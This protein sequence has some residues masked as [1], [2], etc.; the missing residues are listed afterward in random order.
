MP[1]KLSDGTIV[2]SSF[3]LEK[4]LGLRQQ[5]EPPPE[6]LDR[7]GIVDVTYYSFD[8]SLH[9]GQ[10]V[11][12]K[13]LLGD[14]K[15]AFD[16][17][18]QI[19]F[20]VFSVIP[21]MDR[22]FMDDDEKTKTVNNSCGFSY[23]MVAGTDRLSNHSFGRAIDIN[24]QINPYIKGEHSYGLDYD[25]TRPGTLTEDSVIVQYFKSRGWE[26][27]GDWTDRKDYMHFEKPLPRQGEQQTNV[28]EVKID[29]SISKDL[30]YK[31]QLQGIS[32]EA[33]FVLGGGN[34]E[35]TDSKGRKSHKTSPYKGKFFP[36]KTG[37]AKA[38]P[39]AAVELSHY[40]PNAK[41]VTMSHRPNNLFQLAE[42]ETQPID[43]PSFASVLSDDIKRAGVDKDRIIEDPDSTSTLTEII[44]V[45]KISAKNDWQNVAV[46]TNDYQIER[47][48]K[49]LDILKDDEKRILLQNQLQFLFK[50][51]EETDF[52]NQQWRELERALSEFKTNST[53]T[54]FV[55]A[56]NVLRKRS[57]HYEVLINELIELNGY[58]N[59]V[60]QERIGNERIEEGKYNFA[61]D[62]FR[63][64]ILSKREV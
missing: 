41:I 39:I 18:T 64:Y 7:L 20:P 57:P 19:R 47:A 46:I 60:E 4:A 29:Q 35:I 22:S 3:T 5:I 62:S 52:F 15:G 42:Q 45:I 11:L 25:P 33:F 44:E 36:E 56:E 54:V 58:K 6:V 34:R 51:G 13:E 24:P 12:D 32:P 38:R 9:K 59:V 21:A 1:E 16:L 23:R 43:Y 37:G 55:S 50:T 40:Y 61:Q 14:V 49:I 8:K 31:E 30:Y 27:G 48:Q 53:R 63:E 28:F 2:D 26:W 10:V 17:I